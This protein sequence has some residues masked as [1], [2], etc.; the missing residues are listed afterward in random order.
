MR[1]FD[2]ST[3]EGYTAVCARSG[4]AMFSTNE[5]ILGEKSL[6]IYTLLFDE[7]IKGMGEEK[8]KKRQNNNKPDMSIAR[9]TPEPGILLPRRVRRDVKRKLCN[10]VGRGEVRSF[11]IVFGT[12]AV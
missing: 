3:K 11:G 1:K 12:E 6:R 7:L 10:S 2:A 9:Q 5:L 8:K 4:A